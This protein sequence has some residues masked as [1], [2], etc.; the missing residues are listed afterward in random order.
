VRII[1]CSVCGNMV[2]TPHADCPVCNLVSRV[3]PILLFNCIAKMWDIPIDTFKP[4]LN[5]LMENAHVSKHGND[6]KGSG[7]ATGPLLPPDCL[8]D[9][10]NGSHY[11]GDFAAEIG[12]RPHFRGDPCIHGGDEI[13]VFDTAGLL[14]EPPVDGGD[15]G[16]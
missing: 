10:R 13:K 1:A 4:A 14:L 11:Y 12:A 8:L 16:S 2:I 7:E 15:G 3:S 5:N 9:P 6:N